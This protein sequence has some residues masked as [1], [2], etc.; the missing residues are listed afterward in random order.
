MACSCLLLSVAVFF[1]FTFF[2]RNVWTVLIFV[3]YLQCTIKV[4]H[5][6]GR[7]S[8]VQTK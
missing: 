7:K 1:F 4:L 8:E 5:Y 3:L 2:C 6:Y